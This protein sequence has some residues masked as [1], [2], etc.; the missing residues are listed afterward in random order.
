MFSLLGD[1]HMRQGEEGLSSAGMGGWGGPT[2]VYEVYTE[3]FDTDQETPQ[4]S[5][6]ICTRWA[7]VHLFNV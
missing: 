3:G 7:L 6:G 5:D 4:A 1:A 2:Q